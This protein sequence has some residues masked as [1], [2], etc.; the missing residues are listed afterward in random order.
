MFTKHTYNSYTPTQILTSIYI[1][2][3]GTCKSFFNIYI[4]IW[5]FKSSKLHENNIFCGSQ[6]GHNIN[7]FGELNTFLFFFFFSQ[8]LNCMS[9][10]YVVKLKHTLLTLNKLEHQ[11]LMGISGIK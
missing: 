8:F 9:Y 6:F 10:K 11:S 4:Y 1:I 2:V 3:Y 7:M 5:L